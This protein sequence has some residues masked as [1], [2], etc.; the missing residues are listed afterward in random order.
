[1]AAA[2]SRVVRKNP[3]EQ[4][5]VWKASKPSWP[6][7]NTKPQHCRPS[8]TERNAGAA[9]RFCGSL[10]FLVLFR[11][12]DRTVPR[13]AGTSLVSLAHLSDLTSGYRAGLLAR[14]AGSLYFLAAIALAADASLARRRP[15]AIS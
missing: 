7:F 6:R 1:M 4:P 3:S 13:F 2:A 14:E 8:K 15:S 12:Y 5:Q 11:V 10:A 9:S